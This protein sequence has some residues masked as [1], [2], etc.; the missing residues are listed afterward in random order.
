M[1]PTLVTCLKADVLRANSGV[2]CSSVQHVLQSKLLSAPVSCP[3]SGSCDTVLSSGYASIFAVPLPLLGRR[4]L[5]SRL[6]VPAMWHLLCRNPHNPENFTTTFTTSPRVTTLPVLCCLRRAAHVLM[7]RRMSS[8]WHCGVPGSAAVCIRGRPQA[9]VAERQALQP[10]CCAGRRHSARQ[11]KRLPSVP[12]GDCVSGR[13][14]RLVPHV[15]SAVLWS[16]PQRPAGLHDEVPV[17]RCS[18]F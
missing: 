2:P 5:H 7:W 1:N 16:L 4:H 10:V 12:P 3:T 15:C 9:A 13:D 14:L 17:T 11:H 6:V 18:T 8:I